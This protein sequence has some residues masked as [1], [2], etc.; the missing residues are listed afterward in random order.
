MLGSHPGYLPRVVTRFLGFLERRILF[1]INPNQ[2]DVLERK[3]ENG[4][5]SH[6]NRDTALANLVPNLSLSL[7]MYSA[8]KTGCHDR[9]ILGEHGGQ[10]LGPLRFTCDNQHFPSKLDCPSHRRSKQGQTVRCRRLNKQTGRP[11]A[12]NPLSNPV[13]PFFRIGRTFLDHVTM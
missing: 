5:G 6:D 12:S 11:P 13:F 10:G 7:L 1:A 9:W 8:V 3:K 4:S 2:A